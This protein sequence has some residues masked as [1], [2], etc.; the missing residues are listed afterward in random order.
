MPESHGELWTASN[1][2][3]HAADCSVFM[4]INMFVILQEKQ[5]VD[6]NQFPW[7]DIDGIWDLT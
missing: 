4:Y 5:K 7:A 1:V 3:V 6:R 2:K